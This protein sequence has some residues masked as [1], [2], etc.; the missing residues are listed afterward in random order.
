MDLRSEK[1]AF[2]GKEIKVIFTLL[3]FTL[4]WRWRE[5]S[6]QRCTT[7]LSTILESPSHVACSFPT[8][9]GGDMKEL[10]IEKTVKNRNFDLF[11]IYLASFCIIMPSCQV[12]HGCQMVYSNQYYHNMQYKTYPIS[13]S[14]KNRPSLHF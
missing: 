14:R 6:F 2:R 10:I 8:Q 7:F 3:Y 9:T 4:T 12:I 13:Q 11:F 1:N 5:L